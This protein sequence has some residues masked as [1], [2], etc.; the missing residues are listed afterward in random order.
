MINKLKNSRVINNK[1]TKIH[2]KTLPFF[3]I[4]RCAELII[5]M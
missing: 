4:G 5:T 2:E 3:I 1:C